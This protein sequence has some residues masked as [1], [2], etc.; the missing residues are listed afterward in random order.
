MFGVKKVE[1]VFPIGTTFT[2][3]G[4]VIQKYHALI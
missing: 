3:V 1:K 4:E 2:I